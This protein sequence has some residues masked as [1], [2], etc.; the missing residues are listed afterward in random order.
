MNHHGVVLFSFAACLLACV[1]LNSQDNTVGLLQAHPEKAFPG[2]N[3]FYPHNQPNVFL[4]DNCGRLVHSWPD[5]ETWRPGNAVYILEN[6]N[7]VKTKRSFSPINDPIWAGGG[8]EVVEIR[9]WDNDLLYDFSLNDSLFRLHHDLAP[10]PNGNVLAIAWAKK[11]REEAL[12]AGRDPALLPNDELW[13]EAVLEWD[14]EQDTIIWEWHLWDHLVQDHDPL[15]SNFGQVGAHPELIDIN[16]DTHDGHP[17]WLHINAIDY[18]PV[19]DQIVLSVPYFNEVWIVDHSTSTEE[20]ASHSGGRSGRGGD[21]LYRWG[22]PAAYRQGDAQDQKLF[23]QHDS[24]W[25]DPGATESDPAFGQLLI[26]NNRLAA[27]SSTADYLN[28]PFDPG[29]W[30]YRLENG[31]FGPEKPEQRRFHPNGAPRAISESVSSAQHLPNGNILILS[32]RWGYAYEMDPEGALVWEYVVPLKAGQPVTQGDTL[33][34]NNNLTFRLTRY[35]EDFPGFD[36]KDLSPKGYIELEP[37]EGFCSPLTDLGD[38]P[39]EKI[40]TVVFPN[41]FSE[42]LYV[43][44]RSDG[45]IPL[46]V[47]DSQGRIQD[48]M[49]LRGAGARMNTAAWPAGMYFLVTPQGAKK[50][51]KHH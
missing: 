1:T 11:T 21:I 23:F 10:L 40:E 36:G 34:L 30:S 27:D 24:H 3:L 2:Y 33:D 43:E 51:I 22:N 5:D 45:T 20:A 39:G 17:D 44:K 25:T 47:V 9:T 14:P 32:G 37:N 42:V 7:L 28:S 41:P 38:I 29:S 35:A 46:K 13:S 8:G 19:L 16:Y 4:V 48:A 18:N 12:E 26:F 31:K 50:L 15:R 49:L 6:G